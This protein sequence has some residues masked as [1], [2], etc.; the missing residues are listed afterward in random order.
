[1]KFRSDT[2]GFIKGVRFYKGSQN[3]GTHVGSLWTASGTRLATATFADETATRL[4]GGRRSRR[5]S[6][7]RPTPRTWRRTTREV[8]FYASD[9]N[10][11]ASTGVD[12]PPLHALADGVDDGKGV[13]A[14][15]T[16]GFPT[17]SFSSTNYWVDVV[18]DT[19]AGDSTAPTVTART[20]APGATG[21]A[22]SSPVTATFSEP[23]QPAAV[24]MT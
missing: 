17:F 16:G 18:F 6:R 13:Y 12:A 15:G 3:T 11:F 8:G 4:A 1:M 22:V 19:T 14:Y 21:V 20:P 24:S 9:N 7:S 5:R 10:F 23:V 2:A